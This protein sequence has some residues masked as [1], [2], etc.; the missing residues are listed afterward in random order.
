MLLRYIILGEV[1]PSGKLSMSFPYTEGQLPMHY[2]S[3]STGRPKQG[4]QHV[5]RFVSR[6]IDAP[7]EPLF[8]FGYGLSYGDVTYKNLLLSNSKI[9][10]SE[11]LHVKVTV[12]K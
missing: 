7:N 2:S 12:Q 4:S 9:D 3:L 1:S 6:Y 5:G 8:A 11:K 10:R